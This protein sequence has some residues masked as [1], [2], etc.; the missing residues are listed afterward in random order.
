MTTPGTEPPGVPPHGQVPQGFQQPA[1]G[2]PPVYG[3]PAYVP[4]RR[5]WGGAIAALVVGLVFGAGGLGL[6]WALSSGGSGSDTTADYVA[7]CGLI[8]RTEP[9]TKDFEL[10]DMRRLGGVSELAAALAEADSTH[11][12]LA[13][14]LE[15]SIRAAQSFDLDQSRTS[16]RRAQDICRA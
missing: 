15:K 12:P 6:V 7:V 10:G 8:A 2:P 9:L 11:K 13:D 1:D 3:P 5:R 16:L 4:P 14:A